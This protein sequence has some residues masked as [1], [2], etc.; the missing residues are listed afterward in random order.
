MLVNHSFK[1]TCRDATHG[2]NQY[3]FPL[4]SLVAS[5]DFGKGYL[6]DHL[7][8]NRSSEEVLAPFLEVIKKKYTKTFQIN[9]LMIDDDNSGWNALENFFP[10]VNIK[11]LLCK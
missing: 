7:I 8:S 9:T 4:I 1:I 10:S 5:D 2:T 3:W 11:H 6:V